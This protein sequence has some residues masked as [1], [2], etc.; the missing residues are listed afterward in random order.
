MGMKVAKASRA[1]SESM[2]LF[3]T[4]DCRKLNG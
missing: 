1:V 2:L 4:T 3:R